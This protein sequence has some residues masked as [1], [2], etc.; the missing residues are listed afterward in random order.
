VSRNDPVQRIGERLLVALPISRLPSP[1]LALLAQIGEQVA[2][3][4][5]ITHVALVELAPAWVQHCHALLDQAV[6][7][8][9]VTTDH[10]LARHGMLDQIIVGRI[11]ATGHHDQP[12][13]RKR[14]PGH[15]LARHHHHLEL[16][17]E[18]ELD[19]QILGCLG[20]GIGI[21]PYTHRIISSSAQC[22]HDASCTVK[23]G[24]GRRAGKM[25]PIFQLALIRPCYSG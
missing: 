17:L 13:D 3:G 25:A 8:R 19:D 15:C 14:R 16:A 7:Q 12:H 4:Q 18:G 11:H 9:H 23:A 10:Q 5:P 21:D 20:A 1:D 24:T 2:R 6:G 22:A